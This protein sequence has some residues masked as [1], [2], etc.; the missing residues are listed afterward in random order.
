LENEIEGWELKRDL[1]TCIESAGRIGRVSG[2]LIGVHPKTRYQRGTG[3]RRHADASE[4]AGL[5]YLRVTLSIS[6]KI[7]RM[8]LKGRNGGETYLR[9][10]RQITYSFL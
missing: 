7:I 8:A 2:T 5:K 1:M 3:K 10:W 6:R 9:D 4:Y